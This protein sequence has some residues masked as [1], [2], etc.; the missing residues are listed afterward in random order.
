MPPLA[1]SQAKGNGRRQADE[2]LPIL[3]GVVTRR[4]MKVDEIVLIVGPGDEGPAV[5][6]VRHRRCS[7]CRHGPRA[8]S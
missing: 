4:G 8:R 5:M 3:P 7:P 6:R 1:S 2:M